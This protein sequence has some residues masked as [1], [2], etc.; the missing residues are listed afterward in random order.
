[1]PSGGQGDGRIQCH[2]DVLGCTPDA[3][4]SVIKKNHRKLVLKYHPD[5]NLGDDEAAD[6]FILVQ[7]AY[8]VLTDPQERKWYD[9]HRDAILAGWSASDAANSDTADIMLFN[10]A[11]YMHPGCYSSFHDLKGGFYRVYQEVFEHIVSCE[12]KQSET[13]I[14]LPTN[15][16]TSETSWAVVSFFYK[17]WECFSSALN[18]AWED[19]YNAREDAPS[20]RVR[21]LMEEENNKAR[22]NAKKVYK[23]DILQLVAFVKKRDPRN[24][25]HIEE[26]E[27]LKKEREEKMKQDRID[28]KKEKQKAKEAWR[29]ASLREMEKAEE[30]DRLRGRIRL[31]DLEDDY[32]YG[33]GKKKKRGKKKNRKPVI[34]NENEEKEEDQNPADTNPKEVGDNAEFV[35]VDCTSTPDDGEANEKT[36]QGSVSPASG[37]NLGD[38]MSEEQDIQSPLPE[39]TG[40]IEEDDNEYSTESES[41]DEEPQV[42]R[43]DICRKEFKSEAQLKNH[44]KS[45]KHKEAFKKH[46][47]KMKKKE[48]EIMAEMMEEMTVDDQ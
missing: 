34:E 33:G 25:A 15:F 5:K 16:G 27:R 10:V 24:K 29:E 2:Y 17:S 14:E 44:M 47:A 20:R 37:A 31:A 1:M 32:D 43:C 21:R 38:Q 35:P 12:R 8:E 45:K 11:P 28:R 40:L 41:E 36:A 42:W 22:K 48:A 13:I 23:N 7:R 46:M 26:Q 6:K 9:D 18:F 3:D 4:T 39:A 30:E 19:T